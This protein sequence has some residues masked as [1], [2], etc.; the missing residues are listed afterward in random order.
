MNEDL[1]IGLFEAAK[2]FSQNSTCNVRQTAAILILPDNTIYMG[3]NGI[4]E[5]SCKS[6]G[7]DYCQRDNSIKGLEY[8]TC[9]SPCAEGAVIAAALK[10]H[11]KDAVKKSTLVSTDFPCDR[12]KDI[13]ID[14][15]ISDFFFGRY[16]QSEPRERDFLF[17]A[18][19]HVNG[20]SVNQICSASGS[21]ADYSILSIVPD[22][23]LQNMARAA[24]RNQ[25]ELFIRL[26]GDDRFRQRYAQSLK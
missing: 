17:A 21:D 23:Q 16:K 20:V 11:G 4:A 5:D 26:I 7:K 10:E 3:A 19:M 8:L 18:Q 25:G 1:I 6:K 9:P 15:E 22:P 24:V 13:I 2:E 14:Y 12:C